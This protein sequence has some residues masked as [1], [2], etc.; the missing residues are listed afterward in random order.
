MTL[1]KELIRA[2]RLATDD[3]AFAFFQHFIHQQHGWSMR[4]HGLD[5]LLDSSM[6][7]L[8]AGLRD[9]RVWFLINSE[10]TSLATMTP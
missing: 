9:G 2:K 8:P 10:S 1:E 5:L 3:S 6:C 4:N 7:V